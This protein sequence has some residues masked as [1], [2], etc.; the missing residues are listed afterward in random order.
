MQKYAS[1]PPSV[2]VP[3]PVQKFIPKP[4][5]KIRKINKDENPDSLKVSE[6]VD[7]DIDLDSICDDTH[8]SHS[9][10]SSERTTE[11]IPD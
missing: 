11:R 6:Y 3:N 1:I 7:F 2:I 4:V 9:V 10:A 5:T 8:E